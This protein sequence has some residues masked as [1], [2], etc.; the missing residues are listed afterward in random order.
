[1]FYA[2][3]G[4]GSDHHQRVTQKGWL[5]VEILRTQLSCYPHEV[6]PHNTSNLYNNYI[7]KNNSIQ[8]NFYLGTA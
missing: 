8:D 4:L 1:M 6:W 3:C 7:I 2:R 5:C